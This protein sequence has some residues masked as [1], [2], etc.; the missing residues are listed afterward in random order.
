MLRKSFAAVASCLLTLICATGAQAAC[1]S[2]PNSLT[3]GTTA[4]ATQVMANF[5]CAALT[6]GATLVNVNQIGIG[7]ASPS[8]SLD[9]NGDVRLG[10]HIYTPTDELNLYSGNGVLVLAAGGGSATL[11]IPEIWAG[12]DLTLQTAVGGEIRV[13]S[14]SNGVY[15]P[16]G[17]TAWSGISDERL[18]TNIEQIDRVAALA[19]IEKLKPVTFN[20]IDI[21]SPASRYQG[22]I[23]QQVRQVFP[24]L[25]SNIGSKT[26]HIA[27]GGTKTINDALS[28]NYTTLIVPVVGAVQELDAR[29]KMIASRYSSTQTD[30]AALRETLQ[31]QEAEIIS[32]RAANGNE[33]V[34]VNRM[35][36]ELG[37]LKHQL[38][39]Q[40]AQN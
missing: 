12:G 4:D 31:K 14:N 30:Q 40:T 37:E 28:V 22:L 18:K 5:N 34:I 21:K 17:A 9:V 38:K 36:T 24:D 29:T 11:Q 1:S 32:L 15:L 16:V 39:V 25:V 35:Q 8:Y 23:A 26:I 33:A 20:W 7:T 2:Y 10:A 19:A 13:I 6:S 27:G 3:N